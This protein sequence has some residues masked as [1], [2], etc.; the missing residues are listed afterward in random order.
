MRLPGAPDTDI[1]GK[2]KDVPVLVMTRYDSAR[3][4]V[5]TFSALLIKSSTAHVLHAGD[6]RIYLY[7]DGDLEQ[8]TRDHRVWA[9]SDREFLSRAMGAEPH[10]EIDYRA[11]AVQPDD[12]FVF[13][14]DGVHDFLTLNELR[15]LLDRDRCNPQA[16]SNR[17]VSS[18]LE[19]GSNDNAT[20][21][22]LRIKSLGRDDDHDIYQRITEQPFP[23]NLQAGM[24]IDGYEILRELHA[25]KRSEVFLAWDSESGERLVLK[26]PSENYRDDPEFLGAFLH[27]EW[28]GRRVRHP[29][30]MRVLEPRRRRFL[31]H[32]TEYIEGC[33]LGRWMQDNDGPLDLEQVRDATAQII[34]GLRAL[35]R[36]EIYHQDLKPD[37]VLIDFGSSRIAGMVEIDSGTD[38]ESLP[39]RLGGCRHR[40]GGTSGSPL[41]LRYPVGILPGSEPSQ[42]TT[43]VGTEHSVDRAPPGGFLERPVPAAVPEQSGATISHERLILYQGDGGEGDQAYFRYANRI[44]LSEAKKEHPHYPGFASVKKGRIRPM[45]G[46]P[47]HS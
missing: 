7:R 22:L 12:V 27:E 13:T 38:L 6:S 5:A 29:H 44:K 43:P 39:T 3:G 32:I 26:T 19:N 18:A 1:I 45:A 33:S 10:L 37:N 20:C 42:P 11:L 17:I 34:A 16:C 9:S 8:L 40:Q 21:Q 2:A 23:P 46:P 35:H 36:L 15:G 14:S 25:S 24:R 4:M 28:V 31:Y 41:S 30:L 47:N